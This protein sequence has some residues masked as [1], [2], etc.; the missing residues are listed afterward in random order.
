MIYLAAFALL[1]AAAG[2]WRRCRANGLIPTLIDTFAASALGWIAG[3][4]IG[5]GARVGMWS[6]PFFNGTA[7]RVTFDGTVQVVLIF[8]LIG[9]ALS[10]V[11]E[12]AFR[13]FL[14]TRGLL[15]GSLV[16]LIAAYP[17][18]LPALQQINFTPPIIPTIVVTLLVVGFMFVP[19]ALLL[20]FLLGVYHRCR[21]R[22]A[23]TEKQM[24]AGA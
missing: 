10:L 7:S 5:V 15:F 9:I 8:S 13:R 21:S 1:I 12:L 4:G 18:A 23:G 2:F 14:K 19:F 16:A 17:L 24:I 20:E 11:Y 3:L 6:I 22:N